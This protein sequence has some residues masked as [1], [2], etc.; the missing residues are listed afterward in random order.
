LPKWQGIRPAHLPASINEYPASWNQM[1]LQRNIERI[2]LGLFRRFTLLNFPKV[3]LFNR[4][5]LKCQGRMRIIAFTG[6]GGIPSFRQIRTPF[7]NK[8]PQRYLPP[9]VNTLPPSLYSLSADRQVGLKGTTTTSWAAFPI[10]TQGK[11][12]YTS[13][14]KKGVLITQIEGVQKDH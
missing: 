9:H 8:R 3:T 14:H 5:C 1:N 10:D 2:G 12:P 7:T 11:I 13:A 4:A 6:D